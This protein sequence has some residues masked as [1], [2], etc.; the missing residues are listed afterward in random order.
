MLSKRLMDLG[1]NDKSVI[2]VVEDPR[3]ALLLNVKVNDGAENTLEL[4]KVD[5]PT[6]APSNGVAEPEEPNGVA[7]NGTT[8]PLPVIGMKRAAED[9]LEGQKPLK[10]QAK[11]DSTGAIIID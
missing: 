1:I 6:A 5:I 4:A 8:V 7:T 2:R 11:T 9:D 3:V 10:I